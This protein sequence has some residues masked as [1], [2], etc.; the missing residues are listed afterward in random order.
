MAVDSGEDSGCR[1]FGQTQFELIQQ[2]LV[3]PLRLSMSGQDQVPS[4][5]GRQMHVEHL[6]GGELLQDG[7][8][9]EPR[10]PRSG[11]VF[12]RHVQAV[13]D[14]GDEDVRLDPILALMEDRPYCASI[15]SRKSANVVLSDVLPGITS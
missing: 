12:Q 11:Q 3:F 5:G 2:E 13:G 15:F 10:R 7:S 1:S 6:Q 14:E 9:G 8:W 4:V